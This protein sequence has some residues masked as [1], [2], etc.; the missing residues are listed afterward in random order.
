MAP[1]NSLWILLYLLTRMSESDITAPASVHDT[2]K[3]SENPSQYIHHTREAGSR[4][5]LDDVPK[6]WFSIYIG[7]DII[8]IISE[9]IPIQSGE[10]SSRSSSQR[11][12]LLPPGIRY[13]KNQK[14][15]N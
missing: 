4:L 12:L 5:R 7:A 2:I 9:P 11:K 13:K 1:L 6:I 8:T 15:N 14:D 3:A 10:K